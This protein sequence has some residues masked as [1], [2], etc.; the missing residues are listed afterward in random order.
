MAAALTQTV[1][2]VDDEPP[3]V[4]ALRRTLRGRGY[5][6]IGV[7]SPAEALELLERESVDL[8][9]SD[10]DMPGISGLDL[11]ARVRREHPHAVRILLTGRGTL[12]SAVRAIND[13]EV[14]RFLTKPWDDEELR[15]T[16]SSALARLD[17]LRRAAAADQNAARRRAL[18]ADLER[19]QPGI[20]AVQRDADGA[21]VLDDRRI[22]LIKLRAGAELGKLLE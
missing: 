14:H 16:V 19:E 18:I 3:I 15:E 2:L 22:A 4:A 13:G 20:S 7:T 21:Y 6:I 17:E 9:I 5:R 10:I 11:V 1:L 12:D 8:V